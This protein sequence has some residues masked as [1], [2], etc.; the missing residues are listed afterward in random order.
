MKYSPIKSLVKK[1]FSAIPLIDW[2]LLLFII[3]L[4][5]QTT[6]NLFFNELNGN[7]HPIDSVI[8][9]TLAG[10]YGYFMGK[11]FTQI[12][13]KNANEPLPLSQKDSLIATKSENQKKPLPLILK[14]T[15]TVDKELDNKKTILPSKEEADSFHI[16]N[17]MQIVLIG[18]LGVISLILLIITRNMNVMTIEKIATLTQLRDMISGSTGF[19]ISKTKAK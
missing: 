14:D 10:L 2:I 5:I 19:L 8:R 11:D 12:I 15:L 18:S 1:Y 4:M 13:N 7:S 9:T 17:N 3:I 6:Y 16:R